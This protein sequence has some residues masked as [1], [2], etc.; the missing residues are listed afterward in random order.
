MNYKSK[1]TL[2]GFPLIHVSTA[3]MENGHVRR[4][5]AK[6]WI[7]IGDIS[8]GI[9]FS[10]GGVAFGG[11]ALGGMAIGLLSFAGLAIGV[12]AVGGAAV[13]VLA[14]GGVAIAWHAAHGGFAMAN[15]YALGGKAIASQANNL[16]ADEYFKKSIFF[17]SAKVIAEHSRWLILLAFLPGIQSLIHKRK[18]RKS[19]RNT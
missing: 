8:F 9:I 18:H 17:S 3:T 2:L 11:I 6:G 1:C 12:F 19:K 10:M 16:I 5:I 4:G 13:G 14:T 7:A 15:E